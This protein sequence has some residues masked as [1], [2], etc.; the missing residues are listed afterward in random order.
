LVLEA[1][2]AGVIAQVLGSIVASFVQRRRPSTSI[3]EFVPESETVIVYKSV[4]RLGPL[5]FE[6]TTTETRIEGATFRLSDESRS[7]TSRA[8]PFLIGLVFGAVVFFA[9]LLL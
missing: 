5:A 4:I 9:A 8:Q 1:I 6:R 2:V 7:L 3:I